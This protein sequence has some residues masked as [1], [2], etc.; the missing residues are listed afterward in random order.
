[1]ELFPEI[2]GRSTAMRHLFERMARF[3]GSD[4]AIHVYGETGTGKEKVARALHARSRRPG[5]FVAVNA[6]GLGDEL[7]HGQLFGHRRGAFTGAV[8]DQR[9]YVA[10]AE[11]G[12]LFLDEVAELSRCSQ[13]RLLR[14]LQERE[15][16]PLGETRPRRANVRLITA[17][18]VRLGELV[19]EGRF[20]RDLLYRLDGVTLDVPPLRERPEDLRLLAEHFREEDARR[21]GCARP[22][23]TPEFWPTLYA[24][25]WPG[26][27]R[28]LELVLKRAFVQAKGRLLTPED[29]APHVPD[30]APRAPSLRS[31]LLA[32]ER[33]HVARV[34]AQNGGVRQATA[35]ALG[36]TR[37]ALHAK[38]RRFGL[39]G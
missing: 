33:T 26:N 32:C 13:A 9:G 30:A 10:A 3:A 20:R 19:D 27:V 21:D 12:T 36:I 23:A 5:P 11:G 2:L 24:Y 35:A 1:M 4:L 14:F 8:A 18:N 31:F 38:L 34:L 17:T 7:F 39:A 29:L 6:A 37:Q 16:E 22:E 25:D 28:E 15:Y